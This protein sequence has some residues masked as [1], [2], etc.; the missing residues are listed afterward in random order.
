MQQ[1]PILAP[2]W[3]LNKGEDLYIVTYLTPVEIGEAEDFDV[4]AEFD[5]SGDLAAERLRRQFG[6]HVRQMLLAVQIDLDAEL[7]VSAAGD[8]FS[9][10]SWSRHD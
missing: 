8:R 1:F 5:A 7:F 4:V 10:G 9:F 2:F 6:T 3:N